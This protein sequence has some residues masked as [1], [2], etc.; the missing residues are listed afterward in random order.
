MKEFDFYI[1]GTPIGNLGDISARAVETLRTVD[2]IAAEDTRNTLKLLNH[3]G[4]KKP[5]ISYFEHNKR[6]RGEEIIA[7]IKEGK[8]GALVSDGGHARNFRIRTGAC[9]QLYDEGISVTAVPGPSAFTTAL[10]LSG[11][12][13]SR[14]TFEGFLSTTKKN[15][16]ARLEK[17]KDIDS[18]LIFYEG[19]TKVC[20]T[21][22][23]LLNILG[24]RRCAV[25]RE[26]TKLYEQV[27]R[28]TISDQ[29]EYFEQN[30]PR[31]EFVIIVEGQST[32][33]QQPQFWEKLSI[34]DHVEHYIKTGE[35]KKEAIKHTAAD[36]GVPKS[37]IYNAVMKKENQDR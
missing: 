26:L 19:P 18:T 3:F 8:T 20:T 5:M 6:R 1:V 10:V 36:R 35:T 21:L 9:A 31:G 29:L 34:F 25:V 28:S 11:L 27:R 17:L 24:D 30:E 15:R 16:L 37:L 14:F 33:L 4:I 2:F 22:A 12:D 32:A 13:T 7:L 23:D